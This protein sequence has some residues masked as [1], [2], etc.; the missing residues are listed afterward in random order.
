MPVPIDDDGGRRVDAVEQ[1]RRNRAASQPDDAGAGERDE[2]CGQPLPA[3]IFRLPASRFRL[4]AGSL[5]TERD[6]RVYPCRAPCW[7]DTRTDR[8]DRQDCCQVQPRTTVAPAEVQV[9]ESDRERDQNEERGK[10][11]SVHLT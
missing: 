6:E 10:C 4:V 9:Q 8:D 3:S 7:E 2:T 5:C 11:L 1:R